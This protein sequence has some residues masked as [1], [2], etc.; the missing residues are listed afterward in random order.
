MT[1]ALCCSYNYFGITLRKARK[2]DKDLMNRAEY[3]LF[4]MYTA[5]VYTQTTDLLLFSDVVITHKN[6]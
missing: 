2:I 3:R 1:V 4:T 5:N 6:V